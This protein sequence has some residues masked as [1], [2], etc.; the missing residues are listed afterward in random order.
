MPNLSWTD[1]GSDEALS[2]KTDLRVEGAYDDD[3]D[4]QSNKSH[5]FRLA[6]TPQ[7]L[8]LPVWREREMGDLCVVSLSLSHFLHS[9]HYFLFSFFTLYNVPS[10]SFLI[11]V[12]FHRHKRLIIAWHIDVDILSNVHIKGFPAKGFISIC[13]CTTSMHLYMSSC[14]LIWACQPSAYHNDN[15]T[16]LSSPLHPCN[17]NSLLSDQI[18]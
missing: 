9:S 6:A 14:H 5:D 16:Q 10:H 18:F 8:P 15:Q 4:C 3:G 12:F 17:W 7:G 13:L 2:H 1:S 11:A